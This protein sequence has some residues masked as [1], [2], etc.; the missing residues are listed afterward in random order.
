[1]ATYDTDWRVLSLGDP[2]S[3]LPHNHKEISFRSMPNL[4]RAARDVLNK[5]HED[6]NYGNQYLVVRNLPPDVIDKFD[7]DKRILGSLFA[8]CSNKMEGLESSKSYQA[9]K[10]TVQKA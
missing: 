5:F 8:L 9:R 4:K 2:L 3:G 6:T 10:T 1:M 7:D